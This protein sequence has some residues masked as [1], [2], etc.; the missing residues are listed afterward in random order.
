MS[1][2]YDEIAID[3]FYSTFLDQFKQI[4]TLQDKPE[5]EKQALLQ[6]SFCTEDW[7]A[8]M[9][10]YAWFLTGF[11][12]KQNSILYEMF[13]VE[14]ADMDTFVTREVETV[15]HEAEQMHI[16]AITNYL[17]IQATIFQVTDNGKIS[18]STIP[19]D[20]PQGRFK[21]NLLFIPGHY[22]A[23]YV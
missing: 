13:L 19:E 1:N 5:E 14:Y 11:Y 18:P 17:G 20:N 15:N 21:A 3:D 16:I 6:K 9:I 4:E 8:Y 2:G 10:M 12:L 23:L 22:E 7:G